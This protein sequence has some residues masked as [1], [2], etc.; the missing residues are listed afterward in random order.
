[1]AT[2]RVVVDTARES[3]LLFEVGE[4]SGTFYVRRKGSD[5]GKTRSLEDAI[6]LIKVTA[7]ENYGPVRK[8]KIE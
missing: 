1:M 4:T 6:A 7:G 3:G 5:I 8:V 2:K